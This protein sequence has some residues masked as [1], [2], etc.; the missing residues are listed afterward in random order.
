MLIAC[1]GSSGNSPSEDGIL[2]ISG[3]ITVQRDSDV[4]LD[5]NSSTSLNNDALDPQLITNPST[6]GGYL[7][8]YSG[9]YSGT[10]NINFN[11]DLVD[12]F[13]VSLV[14][15]QELQLSVFQADASLRN[16]ELD[17]ILTDEAS[18]EQARL[19]LSQFSS[20]SVIVPADGLYT[21]S[22]R[23]NNLTSPLL[24][25]LSLSQTI[26]SQT[27]S[28]TD[29]KTLSQDFIPGEVLLSFKNKKITPELDINYKN[30]FPVHLSQSSAAQFL[31]AQSPMASLL[32]KLALKEIIPNIAAVY[33]I[34]TSSTS[35][36]AN[37]ASTNKYI[38]PE[39][40]GQQNL[41]DRKIQTLELIKEL[42]A[43][44]LV[45][46][47]EP[48]FIYHSAATTKDPRLSDQWNLSMLSAPAAW[49]VASGLG[50]VI[51]VLDTGIDASHE[52]LMNNISPDG[53]D[54]ITDSKSS[55]DG[56]GFDA[57]P[58]DEG[59]SF[60]G[61]HVTG[62]IAAEANNMKG[63]AGLAYD[64]KIMTLRV[65]GVQD[66]GSSS[67][68]AQAILYA[69][70]LGN[71]SGE[72]PSQRADIINMSFG[73]EALSET[74][75]AAI[76]QAYNNGLILIAAAGNVATDTEFYPAAFD[77]V[78]GVG[79]VSNDKK[80]ASFSNFGVNVDLVAPGGTGSGSTTFDGF[81]DAILST[82]NANNYA[83]YLGTSMAAPHVAAVAALMKELRPDL[84]GQSFKAALDSGSLTLD[85][86]NNS[87]DTNNFYGMGL[88]DAAKSVNWAA[89]SEIIPGILNVY[90]TQ[91]GFIGANTK[92]ELNL[93]NPGH[94]SVKIISIE[95]QENWLEI[96]AKDDVSNNSLLGTYIVEANSALA[97][98]DQGV[99][100][101][102]Y[103]I[104]NESIQQQTI[105]VFISRGSQSDPNV[106]NL[107]ISLY[108]EEDILNDVYQQAYGLGANL[109]NGAY[110]YC[111]NNVAPGRYLLAASTDHDGDKLSFD[112]GEVVGS[113]PLL[114]RPSFIEIS[115]AS[116]T[117]MNFDIQY[118]SFSSSENSVNILRQ[119]NKN[120]SSLIFENLKWAPMQ[121]IAQSNCSK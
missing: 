69:A 76:D 34:Q 9:T 78:I 120:I 46:F 102:N 104:D 12:H 55:G 26:S 32:N 89:G 121:F 114:T 18:Q 99:I 70:G 47:A 60:H 39:V 94:G 66:N 2:K 106:G 88:I 110:E 14:E 6:I 40:I 97:S 52:D 84:T 42:N 75:K 77:N 11:E 54:F 5:L 81:Q 1:G 37:V 20:N 48:N 101:V 95:E 105:N 117:N 65:L 96:T 115:S 43:S 36:S 86:S 79:A 93:T 91:F 7:S 56:N 80:R 111:F 8:G 25:T 21:L 53:Y 19:D 50:I 17:L 71:V 22:L 118:P 98:L 67:D 3:T 92:A 100:T 33:Q 61:S 29:I 83:E 82:I 16:I 64:S 63:V 62:I 103:Q 23:V 30:A 72:V 44:D 57:N 10:S 119:Q 31:T 68:I 35:P 109:M 87:P 90:P 74:V 49:E 116:L 41:L 59:T 73:S 45:E 108:K 113:F 13:K 4:D 24:Y 58:N 51:A 27:L 15:G 28:V 38:E 112:K 107:F 85:L